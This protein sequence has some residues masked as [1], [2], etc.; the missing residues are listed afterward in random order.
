M[1]LFPSRPI[2]ARPTVAAPPTRFLSG[3]F[4]RF[5]AETRRE[6]SLPCHEQ[7]SYHRADRRDS[8]CFQARATKLATIG[9]GT[10][11]RQ[12]RPPRALRSRRSTHVDGGAASGQRE[13]PLTPGGCLCHLPS[14]CQCPACPGREVAWAQRPRPLPPDLRNVVT[15]VCR[16]ETPEAGPFL[17]AGIT[18]DPR[19]GYVGICVSGF[20]GPRFPDGGHALGR[21]EV[22]TAHRSAQSAA[23]R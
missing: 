10:D 11:L 18:L 9:Q 2:F 12:G 17:T 22:A 3:R 16:P 21:A 4:L 1:V 13:A 15:S 20:H 7:A 19:P 14:S 8:Q 6:G 5:T 23:A